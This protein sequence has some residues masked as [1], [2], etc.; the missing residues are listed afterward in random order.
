VGALCVVVPGT[1]GAGVAMLAA[2][3]GAAPVARL[4]AVVT[5]YAA[6]VAALVMALAPLLGATGAATLGIAVVWLGAAPPASVAALLGGWPA[7]AGLVGWAWRLLPL[8]WR[9]RGWL[10]GPGAGHAS[11]LALWVLVGLALAGWRL[12]SPRGSMGERAR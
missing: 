4:A 11:L 3:H 8:A 12:G 5:V 7:V 9:A 10:D 6:A 2:A 1:L